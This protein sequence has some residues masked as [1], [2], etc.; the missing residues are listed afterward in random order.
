VFR[1][2]S[3]CGIAHAHA[4]SRV[5]NFHA[6][7]PIARAERKAVRVQLTASVVVVDDVARVGVGTG[8]VSDA[9]EEILA[10]IKVGERAQC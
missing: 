9:S 6:W 1:V 3:K 5:A 8:K 4:P 10:D 2:N 7:I